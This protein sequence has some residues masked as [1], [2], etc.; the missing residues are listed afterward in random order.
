MNVRS[1]LEPPVNALVNRTR[2]LLVPYLLRISAR[3]YPKIAPNVTRLTKGTILKRG[4]AKYLRLE[5]EATRYVT[6]HTSIP[7]PAVYDF[8]TEEDGRACLIME[9]KDGQTL[10][11]HWRHLSVDQKMTVMRDLRGFLDELHNLPQ[12]HPK[13]MIGSVSGGVFFDCRLSRQQFLCGPFDNEA[14]YNDWHISTFKFFG[15]QHSP[16]KLQLRQLRDE[17]PND[18]QITFTH[19]DITRGNILIR[20]DGEG[21]SDVSI[22]AVLDWEQAGWRPE[23]WETVKFMFGNQETSEWATLGRQEIFVGY[24]PELQREDELLLISGVPP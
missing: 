15:D 22:V 2:R 12:P 23:Y 9:Y 24:D 19:G 8:W 1:F 21:A 13:G 18:H 4:D 11:R 5:A 14:A 3:T 7:V 16:T 20:V 6:L 10:H 17:M